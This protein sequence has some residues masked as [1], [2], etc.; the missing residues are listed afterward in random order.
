M[1]MGTAPV[2]LGTERM[3]SG[4]KSQSPRSIQSSC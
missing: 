2:T 1:K 4:G 3:K